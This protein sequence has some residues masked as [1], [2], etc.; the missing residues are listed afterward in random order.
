MRYHPAYEHEPSLEII[1]V[2]HRRL[3]GARR[4]DLVLQC[5]TC[6]E[7][8]ARTVRGHLLLSDLRNE[9]NEEGR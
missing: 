2:A 7:V 8:D 9:R 5:T 4:T 6:G 1:G 3:L